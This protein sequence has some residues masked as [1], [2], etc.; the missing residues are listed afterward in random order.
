MSGLPSSVSFGDEDPT[1]M[2][3]L[4]QKS[5][6]QPLVPLGSIATAGVVVLAAKSMKRGEKLKTQKY[7][8][9]RIAFQAITL[10]AL[11]G[12]GL[13][14]GRETNE[15][16]KK[17][18]EDLLREKAKQREKLWIE[19]LERRND[20]IQQRKKRLEQSQA[21]LRQLAKQGF[22]EEELLEKKIK[23]AEK[24]ANK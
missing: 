16:Y 20:I 22:I 17:S 8:R 7:F 3:K 13:Y 2:Q 19:E 14:L 18:K 4:V 5:K 6:E 15:E 9:Y 24:E 23:E 12:G 10:V 21:E 1:L 11:V